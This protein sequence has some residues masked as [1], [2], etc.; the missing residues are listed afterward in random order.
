MSFADLKANILQR[1]DKSAKG[2]I[3]E[4]IKPLIDLINRHPDYVTTS[5][6]SGR[7]VLLWG[8]KRQS[9][10]LFCTHSPV[11]RIPLVDIPL[12]GEV[13]LRCEGMILH[14]K[15]RTI[16]G[17]AALLT[18]AQQAGLKHSGIVSCGEHPVIEI[19]SADAMA[20]PY[21]VDGKLLPMDTETVLRLCNQKFQNNLKRLKQFEAMLT[22]A[23]TKS[24]FE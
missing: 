24:D 4:A 21:A 18:R 1:K 2:E 13:W 3:D 16:A 9:R 11:D 22:L 12:D 19:R 14:V 20:V 23:F 5:S 8:V 6:C 15:C 17:A 10:F 7:I